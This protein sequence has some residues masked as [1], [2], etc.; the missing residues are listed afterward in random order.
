M[1]PQIRKPNDA[2]QAHQ[3]WPGFFDNGCAVFTP[4][5][6][7]MRHNVRTPQGV[8]VWPASIPRERQLAR[9]NGVA[10]VRSETVDTSL[11]GP[12]TNGE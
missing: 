11:E 3:Y 12:R 2:V 8:G 5:G 9:Q 7:G 1:W 6:R 4:P 10:G